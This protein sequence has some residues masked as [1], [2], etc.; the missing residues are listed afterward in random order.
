MNQ[1]RGYRNE[2]GRQDGQRHPQK[3]WQ[4][5]QVGAGEF[6][7]RSQVVR[8]QSLRKDS[9]LNN[10]GRHRTQIRIVIFEVYW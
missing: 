6:T 2:K 3:A 4:I 7:H 5:C 8:Y 10:N 1:G 9:N